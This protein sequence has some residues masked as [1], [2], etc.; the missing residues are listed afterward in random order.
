M[1]SFTRSQWDSFIDTL[2]LQLNSDYG[3]QRITRFSE[4]S[5]FFEDWLK[6]ECALAAFTRSN[7]KLS[8][9]EEFQGI[10]KL[11]LGLKA[12]D[13]LCAVELKHIPTRSRDAKSRFLGPKSSNAVED[14]Q[15]LYKVNPRSHIL[16]KLLILYGPAQLAHNPGSS[17][18]TSKRL[19]KICLQCAMN[20]FIKKVGIKGVNWRCH[21]LQT[22][23]MYIVEVDI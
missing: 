9:N 22:S 10:P 7:I 19:D 11:D 14:F 23:E 21:R 4:L 1:P 13:N 15:K 2:L 12:D 20:L 5:Y 6:A 18:T 8:I 3:Q 16:C 17:C